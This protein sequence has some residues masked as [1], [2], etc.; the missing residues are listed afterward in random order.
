MLCLNSLTSTY[1]CALTNVN[2][3]SNLLA[4]LYHI[5]VLK[6]LDLS[7]NKLG[8]IIPAETGDFNGASIHLRNNSAL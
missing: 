3:L 8:G 4:V 6:I 1:E 2:Y 7:Y 5:D